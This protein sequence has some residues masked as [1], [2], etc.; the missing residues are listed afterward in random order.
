MDLTASFL[1]GSILTL[2]LPVALL[3]AILIWWLVVLRRGED[4]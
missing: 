1:E 3:I 4:A 2:V